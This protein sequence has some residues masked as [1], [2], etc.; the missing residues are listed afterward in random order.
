VATVRVAAAEG[1]GQSGCVER[2]LQSWLPSEVG[3]VRAAVVRVAAV[4][5]A[6]V[7]VAA[8]RVAVGW[9]QSKSATK[10]LL[11]SVNVGGHIWYLTP[12]VEKRCELSIVT[13]LT[14]GVI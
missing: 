9:W 12:I 13:V 3:V 7:R 2:L 11:Q 8:V 4:R 5:V 6:A 1:F 14:N 10:S